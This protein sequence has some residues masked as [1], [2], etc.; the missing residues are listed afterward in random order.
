[1]PKPTNLTLY[2][3]SKF[4]FLV[5]S[6][7]YAYSLEWCDEQTGE[8]EY[9]SGWFGRIDGPLDFSGMEGEAEMSPADRAFVERC[10]AGAIICEGPD[11]RVSV[12]WFD[13][14]SDLAHEWERIES[15]IETEQDAEI[16]D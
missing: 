15:R 12:D 6:L 11:G 2:S 9:G 1:M 5:D 3:L 10:K 13:R 4:R 16:E 14:P 8:A 7:A